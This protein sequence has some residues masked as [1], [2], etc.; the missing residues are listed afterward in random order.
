MIP[1]PSNTVPSNAV[2]FPPAATPPPPALVTDGRYQF[3]TYDG[4]I[5]TISPLDAA[6]DGLLAAPRRI[7]RDLGLK[8]WEAFQLGDDDH[9][10]LGAV[11][12]AKSIG[13]LQVLVVDKK[14]ATIR[15]FETKLPSPMLSVARGLDGT[16]SCG[17]FSGLA[18]SIGNDLG[19]G[20]VT[21]DATRDPQGDDPSLALH[22]TGECGSD[23]A[24]HL[25]IVHPFSDEAALYSHKA[26]MPMHGSLV[27]GDDRVGFTDDR[28][29]LIL[30]DHHGDYPRPMRYDW[31]TGARRNSD[32]VVE[33]FNL[34]D[35]QI[36]KPDVYNE[37]AVWI[38]NELHR[39][40]PVTFTRP[41][42]PWGKWHVRDQHGAVDVTFTPT[43]RSTMHVGPRKVLAEYYAPY[44]WFEGVI[45]AE[46]ATLPVDG[47]F[48]VGEQKRITV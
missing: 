30:D 18:I 48:G 26:M 14:A 46:K 27:L 19:D 8:E 13:L 9:F 35:N 6:G 39:L 32:G 29:F 23:D 38:G 1:D 34:T 16:T 21:V 41:D 25:V 20:I 15:R 22:V 12:N 37:N 17:E 33:G 40:P 7:A 42:G 31:V 44:G 10:V 24:A 43:V 2:P 28:G 5:P 36:R 11:Y 4:P 45:H 47:V 3:G